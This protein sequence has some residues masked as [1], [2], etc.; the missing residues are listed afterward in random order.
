ML[1]DVSR[2]TS[3]MPPPLISGSIPINLAKFDDTVIS[4]P[5]GLEMV[6]PPRIVFSS[7]V[8]S[9]VSGGNAPWISF[10][11]CFIV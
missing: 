1:G 9:T 8:K 11:N 10:A 3:I 4:S 7:V 6:I 5:S 2:L